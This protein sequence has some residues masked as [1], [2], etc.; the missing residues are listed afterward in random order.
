MKSIL[1]AIFAIIA[2]G[3]ATVIVLSAKIIGF[4]IGILFAIMVIAA[5]IFFIFAAM[6]NRDKTDSETKEPERKERHYDDDN[7]PHTRVFR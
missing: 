7:D 4:I 3:L 5:V 1:Y 6:F 2:I